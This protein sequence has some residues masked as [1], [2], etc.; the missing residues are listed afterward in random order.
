MYISYKIFTYYICV[1]PWI[2]RILLWRKSTRFL[3]RWFQVIFGGGRRHWLPKV[4][5]DPE[6]HME[7]GRRLD[8]RN[9]VD[10]WLRDKRARGI[11]AAYVWNK[12]QM[13]KLEMNV[14][15]VLGKCFLLGFF[16]EK[17]HFFFGNSLLEVLFGIHP[18]S[19]TSF[20]FRAYRNTIPKFRMFRGDALSKNIWILL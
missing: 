19:V 2:S 18:P 12:S 5:K 7:E 1:M 11:K 9:L 8:G 3:T 6:D 15:Q 20:H 14:Q 10:D 13:D 16:Y 17:H 4:A